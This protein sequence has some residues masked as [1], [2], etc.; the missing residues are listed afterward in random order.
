MYDMRKRVLTALVLA[1]LL[2]L[3]A[4]GRTVSTVEDMEYT[5][6]SRAL[7]ETGHPIKKELKGRYSGEVIGGVP[8]GTGAFTTKN[9]VGDPWTYTG[10]FKNGTFHGQGTKE[11]NTGP[12]K[13]YPRITGSYVDGLYVPTKQ[14]MLYYMERNDTK[15]NEC[16]LETKA[17]E[18]ISDH[19]NLFPCT[20]QKDME[21]TKSTLPRETTC[22]EM[23]MDFSAYTESP[24]LL[25]ELQVVYASS[26]DVDGNVITTILA[27]DKN[28]DTI[29]IYYLGKC[30]IEGGNKVSVVGIP[31]ADSYY[32][33][34]IDDVPKTY[35]AVKLAAC[36]VE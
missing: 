3:A 12:E 7:D 31:V 4:C 22:E 9:K 25:N 26:W 15:D 34:Y 16:T 18:W 36:Y 33:G 1:M 14:E 17:L 24:V 21:E 23:R 28:L 30:E 13:F 11:W 19:E 8:N 20:S 27:M 6:F 35:P 29:Y 5:L 10:E 2:L 32:V